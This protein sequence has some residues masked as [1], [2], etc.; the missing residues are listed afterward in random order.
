MYFESH[1]HYDDEAF[2]EDRDILL[3]SFKEKGIDYVIN[4]ASNIESSKFG[5]AL[6]KKYDFLYASVGVH[7]H[8]AASLDEESFKELSSLAKEERAVAIGEIGLD[9]HY[10]F[11]PRD[12]QR[13]WFKKQLELAK[14]M[15][16]PVI[17]HSREASQETF[18]MIKEANLSER[19]GK[20]AGVIHCY[21]G[22]TE[23]ALQYIEMGYY[24]GVGGVVTFSNSKKLVKV[25][26]T[27]PLE[28]I[29]IETDCP[30]LSPVPKRG[31]RNSSLYLPYIVDKISQIKEISHDET[32]EV[33]K[34]NAINLFL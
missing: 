18:D 30:Y 8:D 28:K 33:T 23:M 7:P 6:S 17:I 11:S 31:K 27:I 16:M 2:D 13:Y 3:S 12:S 34:L 10:D 5:L 22:S 14:T 9:F 20:G 19:S 24:I 26:K 21:S 29:L 15:D 25:V 32:A 4:S 1:A